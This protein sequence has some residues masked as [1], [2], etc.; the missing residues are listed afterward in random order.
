MTPKQQRALQALMLSPTVSAAVTQAKVGERTLRRWLADGE[1]R[2][3]YQERREQAVRHATGLLQA[4]SFEA[5]EALRDVLRKPDA[6]ASAKVS[7]ARAIIDLGLRG[8]ELENLAERIERLENR[9]G[10]GP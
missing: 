7:A 2:R 9:V 8:I 6:S 5:V 1:F 10:A 3:E 4:A